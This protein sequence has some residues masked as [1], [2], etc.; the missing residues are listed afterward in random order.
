MACIRCGRDIDIEIHHIIEKQDG[1]TNDPDNLE[2]RC[3][4]CHKYEHAKRAI[5][6]RLVGERKR[7]QQD[8][9]E[10]LEYR[11]HVL[12][13]YNTIDQIRE[14]GTYKSYWENWRVREIPIIIY[15]RKE[16]VINDMIN[17]QLG[18]AMGSTKQE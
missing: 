10:F 4:A 12:I 7:G 15:T 3:R 16:K 5:E 2:E 9:I 17:R 13:S 11:L 8:R 18:I 14:R 1:G 6:S